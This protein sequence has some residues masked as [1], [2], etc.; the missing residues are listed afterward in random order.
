MAAATLDWARHA[1]VY[2]RPRDLGGFRPQPAQFVGQRRPDVLAEFS[3]PCQPA[4][5]D[6][7]HSQLPPVSLVRRSSLLSD[8]G[9]RL[10]GANTGKYVR[11]PPRDTYAACLR[12]LPGR[13]V[14]PHDISLGR[15]PSSRSRTTSGA[16]APLR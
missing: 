8:T 10:L 14:V 5:L 4:D 13:G 9:Q 16:T 11:K 6:I 1:L 7:R 3:P 2:Q 15:V 12:C